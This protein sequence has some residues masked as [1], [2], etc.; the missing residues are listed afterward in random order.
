LDADEQPERLLVC[1]CG[2]KKAAPPGGAGP[3]FALLNEP[4][5]EGRFG[6]P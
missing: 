4:T 6:S 2:S 5:D 1:S 3:P